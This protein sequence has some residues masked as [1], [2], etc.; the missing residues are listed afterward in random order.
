MHWGK[1]GNEEKGERKKKRKNKK[2]EEMERNKRELG[3]RGKWRKGETGMK[4]E[5]V[6]KELQTTQPT[7]GGTITVV[8]QSAV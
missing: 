4:G 5:R 7:H 6:G 8:W 2:M 3:G 1:R